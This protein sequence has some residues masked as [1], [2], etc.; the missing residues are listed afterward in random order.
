MSSYRIESVSHFN[1]LEDEWLI[2][3]IV[4]LSCRSYQL[5]VRLLRV[6]SHLHYKSFSKTFEFSHINND[7]VSHEFITGNSID[8]IPSPL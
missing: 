8:R 4:A 3:T 7:Y 1:L 6:V 5:A 2:K